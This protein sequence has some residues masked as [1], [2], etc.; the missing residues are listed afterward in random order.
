MDTI[1]TPN[2]PRPNSASGLN[3]LLGIWLIVSP[4]VLGFERFNAAEWNDIASGIAVALLALSGVSWLNIAL[5]IWLIISPFVLGF[6]A[7]PTLLWNNIILGILVGLVAIIAS[8]IR[9]T[10][11][12]GPPS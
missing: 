3:V 5:G 12:A 2:P 1:K 6:A 7:Y 9:P 11:V 10:T 8:S 4:F